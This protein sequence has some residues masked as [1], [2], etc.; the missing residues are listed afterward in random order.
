MDEN[1]I[2][3]T[4]AKAVDENSHCPSSCDIESIERRVIGIERQIDALY[5][6]LYKGLSKILDN[7]RELKDE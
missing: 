7:V 6:F 3:K 4:M 5:R 1:T 2:Y